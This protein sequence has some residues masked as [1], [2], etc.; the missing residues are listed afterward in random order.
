MD[1]HWSDERT[2]AAP[3]LHEVAT[4]W[5]DVERDPV[6][7]WDP[8]GTCFELVDP[9]APADH[10]LVLARFPDGVDD[11]A[12]I[13]DVLATGLAACDFPPTES[14]ASPHQVARALT[15]AGFPRLHPAAN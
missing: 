3:E 1:S 11:P 9:L 10:R 6:V 2:V 12:R 14:G 15:A 4:I 7:H 8:A 13:A 5:W